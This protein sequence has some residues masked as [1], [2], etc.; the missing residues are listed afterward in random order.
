MLVDG[1]EELIHAFGAEQPSGRSGRGYPGKL[2]VLEELEEIDDPR[3]LPFLLTS[4]SNVGEYDLARM[5]ILN[6]L[7]IREYSEQERQMAGQVVIRILKSD[8]D[9]DVRK[10]AAMAMS[11]FIDLPSAL[12]VVGEILLNPDENRALRSNA[13]AVVERRGP[14]KETIPRWSIV[15]SR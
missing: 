8:P 14:T 4:V 15:D 12:D 1:V 7:A 5:E 11:P 3:I 10:Y 9:N 13:R 6:M 2:S